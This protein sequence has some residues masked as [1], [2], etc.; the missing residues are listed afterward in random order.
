MIRV[1]KP[2]GKIAGEREGTCTYGAKSTS[3]DRYD[4]ASELAGDGLPFTVGTVITV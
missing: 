2:G 3:Q 4:V 1:C